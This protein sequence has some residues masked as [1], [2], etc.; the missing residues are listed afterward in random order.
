MATKAPVKKKPAKKKSGKKVK[1]SAVAKRA[2]KLGL[3]SMGYGRWGKMGRVTHRT[4]A[5][6][7]VAVKDSKHNRRM[8][9]EGK[10]KASGLVSKM[11][12]DYTDKI[13]KVKTAIKKAEGRSDEARVKHL[14]AMLDRYKK[15]VQKAHDRAEALT[16]R[17]KVAKA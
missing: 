12:K 6:Q 1:I 10:A 7:L 8:T 14:N 9:R 17:K 3:E 4:S 11:F 5:G 15:E 16:K 13:V 2:R